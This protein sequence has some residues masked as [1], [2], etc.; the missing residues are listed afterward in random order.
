MFNRSWAISG[1]G[2]RYASTLGL[3]L[4][5]Y[6]RD[7]PD[8]SKEIRYR[9]WWA[10]CSLERLLAVMTGRPTSFSETD[11]TSPLPL[12]LEEETL[13]AKPAPDTRT[14]QLLRRQSSQESW[15][16]DYATSTPSSDVRSS[17][18]KDSSLGSRSPPS[19]QWDED[20]KQ[21]V[22]PCNAL[23]YQYHTRLSIFTNEV[24][25]CIYRA[26]PMKKSWASIQSTMVNLNSK[27]EKWRSDLSTVFDFTK[28]QRDEQFLCQR[29]SLG[30][31]YYS[32]SIIINRPCLCRVDRNIPNQSG[33]ARDLNHDIAT[34]CV[35][36]AVEML[37]LLPDEPNP[38]GLYKIAPWWCLTHFL[39]QAATILMLE[40]SFR[41]DHMPNEAEEIFR[42]AKKSV[43]W[44]RSM[45]AGDE[46][47]RRAWSIADEMLRKT[48]PKV[49]RDPS[50]VSEG[51]DPTKSSQDLQGL[52]SG[53]ADG[54][55]DSSVSE[56][57]TAHF[58][59]SAYA[60]YDHF[61]PYNQLPTSSASATFNDSFPNGIEFDSPCYD[62]GAGAG[63]DNQWISRY[64]PEQDPFWFPGGGG[65]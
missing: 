12:P 38:I 32:T 65:A 64:F 40:L 41:A 36:A 34:K 5:N 45:K 31:S 53:Q 25:Q 6:T 35:H 30:F 2:I 23:F 11:C 9:I 3:N 17:K 22:P 14:I 50:D 1:I 27:L 15:H 18:K 37:G 48:A 58:Q 55:L 60:S 54:L 46:A 47:A 20:R 26:A 56:Y 63:P 59:P 13:F 8:S 44:L 57:Q 24:L 33:K 51:P 42:T 39:M 43:K 19:Q 29:M 52:Q 4:L 62:P 16:K 21:A 10:M 7:V 61:G 28:R 49:G